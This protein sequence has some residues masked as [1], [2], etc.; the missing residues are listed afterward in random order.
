MNLLAVSVARRK[1]L[2]ENDPRIMQ[3]LERHKTNPTGL[4]FG[5][6]CYDMIGPDMRKGVKAIVGEIEQ[7]GIGTTELRQWLSFVDGFRS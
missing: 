6:D 5:I 2:I 3:I 4:L 1:A 7:I